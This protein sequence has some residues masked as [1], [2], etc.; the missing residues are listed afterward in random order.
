MKRFLEVGEFVTTHGVHGELKLYPW[1]DC[2]D[3][4][5]GL[6]RLFFS[7]N[8]GQETRVDAARVHKGMCL[9]KLHGVDS[10]EA[11]RRYIGH[12]AYFDR[13]DVKLPKERYFVQDIIGCTV[14]DADTGEVYG[15]ITAVEHPAAIDIYT[16]KNNAG[17]EFLF[18]AVPEFL[19]ALSPEEGFVTVRPI[20][21]MFTND[22]GNDDV[23]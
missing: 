23:D 1:C 2:P 4:A 10:I 9:V 13:D 11:A 3:F 16:V 7:P 22:G 12:V 6:P 14:R 18:P 19:K 20:E 5:A 21:G 17:E 15:V 8:G